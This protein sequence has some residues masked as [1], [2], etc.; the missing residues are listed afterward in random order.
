MSRLIKIDPNPHIAPRPLSSEWKADSLQCRKLFGAI[1][2][3]PVDR[4]DCI[5]QRRYFLN[6]LPRKANP[7]PKECE[8]K[9]LSFQFTEE[10]RAILATFEEMGTV[11]RPA[12]EQF[13]VEHMRELKH[14]R[15]VI[16]EQKPKQIAIHVQDNVYGTYKY[17]SIACVSLA[18]DK[19][20]AVINPVRIYD[21]V[22]A[23]LRELC[24]DMK[25]LKIVANLKLS[26]YLLQM[27]FDSFLCGAVDI[28][29][30]HCVLAKLLN[31][32]TLEKVENLDIAEI[33]EQLRLPSQFR[34]KPFLYAA[35]FR[36]VTKHSELCAYTAEKAE[37]IFYAFQ[38]QKQM[39]LAQ[40]LSDQFFDILSDT[41]SEMKLNLVRAFRVIKP[42]PETP[43][44]WILTNHIKVS[45]EQRAFVKEIVQWRNECA[46][47]LDITPRSII[48]DVNVKFL[49]NDRSPLKSVTAVAVFL[50]HDYLLNYFQGFY[51]RFRRFYKSSRYDLY[52]E[53][54]S[55]PEDETKLQINNNTSEPTEVSLPDLRQQLSS[56]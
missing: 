47:L 28:S 10:H 35:D 46:L 52:D 8:T 32:E 50:K 20:V 18:T 38:A 9:I 37:L 17:R 43:E 44:H 51:D 14:L 21:A 29:F 26:M 40:G 41:K 16:K 23:F 2:R 55:E 22:G 56:T 30:A 24:T 6:S 15:S 25:V 49:L 39:L 19:F 1:R 11:K 53:E 27:E 34:D 4:F 7:F 3:R 54:L 36:E 13:Q 31:A 45:E 33:Y 48:S 5:R 12:L 42:V